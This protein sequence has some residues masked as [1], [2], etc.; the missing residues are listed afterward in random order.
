[1]FKS[2]SPRCQPMRPKPRHFLPGIER[3][4][5]R[6]APANNVVTTFV[7]GTLTITTVDQLGEAE[8]LAGD[9][10]QDF[11][12]LAAGAGKVTLH[13]NANTTID[14]GGADEPFTGVVNLVIDMKEGSDFV[15]LKGGINLPGD[16]TFKGGDGNNSLNLD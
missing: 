12:I 14:G 10:N 16:V 7:G 4:E 15:V 13:Q 11:Q 6:I 3:L 9:N 2:S 8:I 1:M 5:D